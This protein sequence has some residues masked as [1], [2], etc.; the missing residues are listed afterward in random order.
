MEGGK[1]SECGR[2]C[3]VFSRVCGYFR[4]VENWNKGKLSEF[5]DRLDYVNGITG[6]EVELK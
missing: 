5:K 4:P 2:T 1:M 6:Y 3:E